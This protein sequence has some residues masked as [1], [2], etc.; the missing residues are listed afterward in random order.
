VPRS[1]SRPVFKHLSNGATTDAIGNYASTAST[2]KVTPTLGRDLYVHRLIV[3]IEDVG[4]PDAA[5]YG[6]DITL[7]NGMTVGLFDAADTLLVDFC[8]SQPVKTN[9]DWAGFCHDV[10]L[11]NFGIGNDPLTVRWTFA[12]SGQPVFVRGTNYF[13]VKLNDDFS[14]LVE[15]KFQVQ[16]F[17]E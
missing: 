3:Y 2:F 9:A 11:H 16:G 1:N 10:T 13:G 14:D 6:N 5:K 7:T 15:H 12:R 8:D 17:E 4:A